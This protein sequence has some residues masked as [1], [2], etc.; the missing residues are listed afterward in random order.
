MNPFSILLISAAALAIDGLAIGAR[1]D[2]SPEVAGTWEVT[3]FSTAT[4]DK[5]GGFTL[6]LESDG[7]AL[8]GRSVWPDGKEARI[9]AAEVRDGKVS[10]K[11]TP[12]SVV[13][14]YWGELRGDTIRG[15][16]AAGIAVFE[17]EGRRAASADA[18]TPADLHGRWRFEHGALGEFDTLDL[19]RNGRFVLE[20]R[21]VALGTTTTY[22]TWTLEGEQVILRE[23][24]QEFQGQQVR[25]RAPATE[26]LPVRRNGGGLTLG[27]PPREF[28]LETREFVG[29]S[30]NRSYEA[31]LADALRKM[32]QAVADQGRFPCSKVSWRVVEISG[33]SGTPAGLSRL[34]VRIAATFERRVKP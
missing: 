10:F 3:R 25:D 26:K 23:E 31:A 11:V 19:N 24:R 4:G 14:Q 16:W 15:Q 21:D 7:Q 20:H 2:D 5:L 28:R 30:E 12:G 27:T 6:V 34:E 17:W 29:V 13:Q 22:G 18:V 33:T 8:R 32:D 1:A 9:A